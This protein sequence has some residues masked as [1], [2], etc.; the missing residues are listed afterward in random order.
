[1]EN[2][3][4]CLKCRHLITVDI[5]Y[6]EYTI[7]GEEFKC[8]MGKFKDWAFSDEGFS[9]A[10]SLGEIAEKCTEFGKGE[11]QNHDIDCDI[12]DDKNCTCGAR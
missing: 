10:K 5:G 4:K 9:N 8:A 11:P 3:P 1:M 7:T 2:S 12:R 6:S